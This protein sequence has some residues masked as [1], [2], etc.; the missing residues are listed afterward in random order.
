MGKVLKR[1]LRAQPALRK[2]TN[3]H[4]K[5][6]DSDDYRTLPIVK[7]RVRIDRVKAETTQTYAPNLCLRASG[8][9]TAATAFIAADQDHW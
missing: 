3:A 5:L 9:T 7:K 1:R 8:L 2:Q 6:K 4:S